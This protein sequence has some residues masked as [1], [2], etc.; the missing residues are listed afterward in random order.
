MNYGQ[1]AECPEVEDKILI[2][3]KF[4]P[5]SHRIAKGL[6]KIEMFGVLHPYFS[7]PLT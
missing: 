7:T 2:L 5:T 4:L 3:R 6:G 1:A